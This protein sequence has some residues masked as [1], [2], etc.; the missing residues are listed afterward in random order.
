MRPAAAMSE[1]R[2]ITYE[3]LKKNN[4]K[5]SLYILIHQKGASCCDV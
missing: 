1:T 4:K 2:I 5:D 3:E